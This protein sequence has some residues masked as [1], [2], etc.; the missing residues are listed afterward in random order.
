[1]SEVNLSELNYVDTRYKVNGLAINA[2]EIFTGMSQKLRGLLGFFT[3]LVMKHWL[4][5][6]LPCYCYY[7]EYVVGYQSV[8]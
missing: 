6:V 8:H 1:M 5:H 7:S 4:E 2:R 3:V